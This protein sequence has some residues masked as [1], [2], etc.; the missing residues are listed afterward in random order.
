MANSKVKSIEFD[1]NQD[2]IKELLNSTELANLI[3]ERVDRIAAAAGPGFKASVRR[4]KSR[5]RGSVITTDTA[6]RRAEAE[7]RALTKAVEAGRG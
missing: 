4:G 6:S 2:A 3:G 1:I 7:S 5:V